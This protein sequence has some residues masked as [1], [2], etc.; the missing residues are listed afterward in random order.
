MCRIARAPEVGDF[1]ASSL[2]T[3]VEM[4][5]GGVGITL[6]PMMAVASTART[7]PTLSFV[8]FVRPAPFRTIGLAWRHASARAEEFELLGRALVDAR[9]RN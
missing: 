2:P 5:A 8:P 4:V 7:Q 6:L 1:R 3:L 9:G